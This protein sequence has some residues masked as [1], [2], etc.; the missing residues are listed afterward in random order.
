MEPEILVSCLVTGQ[1]LLFDIRNTCS[2]Q[3]GRQHVFMSM[4]VIDDG[5][6]IDDSRPTDDTGYP[7][8]AFPCGTFLP[9]K[10]SNPKNAILKLVFLI[11]FIDLIL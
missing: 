2:G 10:R 3:N 4:D 6:L 5:P 8:S 11:I 1:Q 7:G 9:G